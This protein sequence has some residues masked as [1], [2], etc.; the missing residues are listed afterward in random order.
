MALVGCRSAKAM[1][2]PDREELSELMQEMVRAS[3]SHESHSFA[4]TTHASSMSVCADDDD[5]S[6]SGVDGEGGG[7]GNLGTKQQEPPPPYEIEDP[8]NSYER[9]SRSEGEKV[10]RLIRGK[11]SF[12]TGLWKF[13]V[14]GTGYWPNEMSK[15][16]LMLHTATP[17]PIL[18]GAGPNP[19]PL[20][21]LSYVALPID[22]SM[23]RGAEAA[24]LEQ[25]TMP[26]LSTFLYIPFDL[27][28]AA[29]TESFNER[30]AALNLKRIGVLR[31]HWLDFLDSRHI[32]LIRQ[33]S[34]LRIS[35]HIS[36]A[37]F[38][39]AEVKRVMDSLV[40]SKKKNKDKGS[41]VA[42]TTVKSVTVQYSLLDT[43]AG[44]KMTAYCLKHGL[45][46]QAYGCLAGGLLSD[47]F[48]HRDKPGSTRTDPDAVSLGKYHEVIEQWG[49]WELFQ[50]LLSTL[51]M[52]GNK[53]RVSIS[54]V[55][56]RWV[57]QQPAVSGVIDD[58]EAIHRHF[59]RLGLGVPGIDTR[60]KHPTTKVKNASQTALDVLARVKELKLQ[61]RMGGMDGSSGSDETDYR[62]DPV[63]GTPKD[64]VHES[65]DEF[66]RPKLINMHKHKQHYKPGE[67]RH[68]E[69]VSER[70]WVRTTEEAV[71]E[72]RRFHEQLLGFSLDEADMLAIGKIL[73]RSSSLLPLL[74]ECGEE[75]HPLPNDG[76]KQR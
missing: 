17:I 20:H 63:L 51:R 7:E 66:N 26:C 18:P 33:L 71:Q 59:F 19:P 31:F 60:V 34:R 25:L 44:G 67:N 46:I 28:I 45:T 2:L 32:D 55:A 73:S 61:G 53:H 39:P 40:L 36:L 22:P 47:H 27:D 52:I 24:Q 13:D 75:F 41:R 74:G 57:M 56:M 49:T 65:S 69:I 64:P 9:M 6:V 42:S 8:G 35:N 48:L 62:D 16:R 4:Q 30:M 3:K 11:S 72:K 14:P 29:I 68:V 37:N 54:M 23:L 38:P 43:R 50:E 76:G 10:L 15:I 58:N 5:M 1:E 70:K 12:H 21:K